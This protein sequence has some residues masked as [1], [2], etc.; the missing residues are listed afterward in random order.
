M[1]RGKGRDAGGT[2]GASA[3]IFQPVPYAESA[4]Q[5]YLPNLNLPSLAAEWCQE[6]RSRLLLRP[7]EGQIKTIVF[8][9]TSRRSGSTTSVAWFAVYLA[10]ILQ[11][12]VLLL[13][14]NLRSP[15]LHRFFNHGDVCELREAVD[16]E[17]NPHVGFFHA[18][19]GN[20]CLVTCNG[21]HG[22]ETPAILRSEEFSG[23]LRRCRDE[24]DYVLIDSAPVAVSAE[25]RLIGSFADGVVLLVES[26]RSRGEVVRRARDEIERSGARFLGAILNRRK[27]HIPGW[28]YRRL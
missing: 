17:Q 26:G 21:R 7:F 13:D 27:F 16:G 22:G 4:V 6:L 10:N 11:K 2:S 8:T 25:T 24:Y 14:L 23:F 3:S 19:Q 12:R 18:F 20:L 1:A 9:G 15:G 5:P 28:L